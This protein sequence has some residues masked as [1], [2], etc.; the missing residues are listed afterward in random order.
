MNIDDCPFTEAL[1]TI[2]GKYE[3]LIIRLLFMDN[4][5]YNDLLR[6]IDDITPRA[7][8][9]SLKR[10]LKNNIIERNYKENKFVYRLTDKGLKLK[11]SINDLE[12]WHN[13]NK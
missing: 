13:K 5:R 2:N 1:K 12:N 4:M 6:E 11:D 8:S 3:P 10:L 7:L 9:S